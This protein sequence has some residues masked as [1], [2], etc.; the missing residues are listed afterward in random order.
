[1][2]AGVKRVQAPTRRPLVASRDRSRLRGRVVECRCGA[3]ECVPAQR[4][5]SRRWQRWREL[6][7]FFGTPQELPKVLA[8]WLASVGFDVEELLYQRDLFHL[9]LHQATISNAA[10]AVVPWLVHVCNEG[11]TRFRVEYLTDVALV[12]ANRLQ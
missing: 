6:T 1:M 9:F 2:L 3:L 11:K 8:Q 4:P 10:F 5:R 7:T 12:E